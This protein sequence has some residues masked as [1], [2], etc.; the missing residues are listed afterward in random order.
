LDAIGPH[1]VHISTAIQTIHNWLQIGSIIF[2][3]DSTQQYVTE[4][5]EVSGP[6]MFKTTFE[7]GFSHFREVKWLASNCRIPASEIYSSRFGS[8]VACVIYSERVKTDFAFSNETEKPGEPFVLIIDEINRGNVSQ[9]FGELITLIEEDKREGK[10][11]A[12][13]VILPYSK[14]PFSVPSNIYIIGTM[15]TADRSVEALDT[16]LRRRFVFEEKGPQP[17][18]LTSSQIHRRFWNDWEPWAEIKEYNYEK[19]EKEL[20]EFLGVEFLDK[21][22]YIRYGDSEVQSGF[23]IEEFESAIEGK[24][25]Y[26]GIDLSNMLTTINSRIEVLLSRDHQIGHS[27][28][29]KVYSEEDLKTA[30]YKSIIP[31]LQEYFYGDYGKIGLV[32]GRGFVETVTSQKPFADFEYEASETLSDRV[33]YQIKD[34]RKEGTGD[35]IAA[36]KSIYS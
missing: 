32:L 11:E 16:A 4:I 24:L 6:Y 8:F 14:E 12:L 27:Y 10:L 13:D 36:V 23:T 19:I 29:M 9:I 26:T 1:S 18:L 3:T 30:F 7:S 15:N 31:L 28:F 21:K 25:T 5:L 20:W 34:Y 22:A 17:N 33:V 35:F 2:L